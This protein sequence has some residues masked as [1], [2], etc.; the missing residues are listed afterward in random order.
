MTAP[1][2]VGD[3]EQL[4][5]RVFSGKAAERARR[6]VPHRVFLTKARDTSISIDRLGMTALD[7]M[8]ALADDASASRD[9]SFHGWACV[10][11]KEAREGDRRVIASPVDGNPYHGE[12]VLPDRAATDRAE[13]VR[14]AQELADASRWLDRPAGRR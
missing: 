7:D 11:C 2:C 6:K 1:A 4:G 14:H 3:E 9:G 5:R 8:A 10:T 13:Q 12:I